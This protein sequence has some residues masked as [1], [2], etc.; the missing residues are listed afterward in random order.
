MSGIKEK[1]H[2]SEESPYRPLKILWIGKESYEKNMD[3]LLDLASAMPTD[4]FTVVGECK[5][6]ELPNINF[7]GHVSH[8]K[9]KDYYL[10]S[11]VLLCTSVIEGMPN[12]FLE[13]FK[14]QIPVVSSLYFKDFE[15]IIFYGGLTKEELKEQLE[16]VRNNPM[17]VNNR[18]EK[19]LDLL[20][21]RYTSKAAYKQFKEGISLMYKSYPTNF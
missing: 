8:D 19:G 7:V 12:I 13:A 16:I 2:S 14:Y 20:K 15:D 10:N 18:I 1:S 6:R 21:E 3:L 5:K 4:E 9:I 17:E 11:D